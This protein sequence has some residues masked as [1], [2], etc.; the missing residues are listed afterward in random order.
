MSNYVE[1]GDLPLDDK[2][3]LRKSMG[4]W[5]VVHPIKIDGKINWLNL[6]FGGKRNMINL[7]FILILFAL[8]LYGFSEVTS[9][10][11]ELAENPCDYC[12]ENTNKANYNPDI[13]SNVELED[14]TL[15][16]GVLSGR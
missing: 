8:L 12:Y 11:A 2:V 16:E 7:F 9:S 4:E 5:G 14:F 15:G 1:A 3:Y 6:L 10:C 13:F